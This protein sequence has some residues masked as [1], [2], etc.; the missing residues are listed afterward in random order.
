MCLLRNQKPSCTVCVKCPSQ[1]NQSD[2]V[3]PYQ[4]TRYLCDPEV[5]GDHLLT[6]CMAIQA[7]SISSRKGRTEGKFIRV[8]YYSSSV[9]IPLR[10]PYGTML[11]CKPLYFKIPGL[12]HELYLSVSL[13]EIQIF[14]YKVSK[15][16]KTSLS[17][18][19]Q[20]SSILCESLAMVYTRNS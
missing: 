12:D 5:C 2:L 17:S 9:Y 3:R 20:Y 6:G 8:A 16:L 15:D 14:L 10:I 18:K 7:V 4:S 1:A 11:T 19:L 13:Y